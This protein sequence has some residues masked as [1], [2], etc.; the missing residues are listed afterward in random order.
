MSM[1]G[2]F[3]QATDE[4]IQGLLADP[5]EILVFLE[6]REELDV[7]RVLE[8]EKNWHA[9][10]WLLTGSKWEGEPPLNFIVLGGAGIG[11]VDVGYGAAR[12]FT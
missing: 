11:D 6:T 5:D 2:M 1:M 10:H 4:E 3:A 7:T 8:L 12:A 9:L